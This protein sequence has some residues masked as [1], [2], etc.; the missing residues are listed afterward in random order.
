MTAL[1][2]L[3]EIQSELKFEVPKACPGATIAGLFDADS[4][5][6]KRTLLG[7]N[8][9]RGLGQGLGIASL[10]DFNFRSLQTLNTSRVQNG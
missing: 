1:L 7:K 6:P 9:W 10:C 3:L 4:N 5:R 2:N 8:W